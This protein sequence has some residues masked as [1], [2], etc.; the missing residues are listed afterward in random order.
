[1][2]NTLNP[3][4]ASLDNDTLTTILVVDTVAN[5]V[6]NTEILSLSFLII[7]NVSPHIPSRNE[8]SLF[9]LTPQLAYLIRTLKVPVP[10]PSSDR[11]VSR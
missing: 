2:L 8:L 11:L 7:S 10:V 9:L 3:D 4:I 5:K 6:W 1:M